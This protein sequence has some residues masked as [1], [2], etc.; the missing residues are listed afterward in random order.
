MPPMATPSE[1]AIFSTKVKVKVTR[2][3]N[4]VSVERA[5]LVEYEEYIS[6]GS[7][8]IVNVKDDN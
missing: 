3:W 1:K 4:T 2:S 8:V 5:S 6:Y 7:K